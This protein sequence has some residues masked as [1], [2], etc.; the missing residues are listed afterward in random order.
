M[1]TSSSAWSFIFSPCHDGRARRH[2]FIGVHLDVGKAAEH[3]VTSWRTSGM[4]AAPPARTTVAMSALRMRVAQGAFDGRA[5][6]G[7]QRLA[8]VG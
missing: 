6:T 3:A 2:H 7:Q 4:R 8:P 5:Q 1:T